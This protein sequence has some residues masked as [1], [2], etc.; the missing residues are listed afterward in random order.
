MN[1]LC[2]FKRMLLVSV[3]ITSLIS[4]NGCSQTQNTHDNKPQFRIIHNNDGTDALA[5]MWIDRDKPLTKADL[6]AYVDMVADAGSVTTYMMC[7]GS[8][9]VYYR[10][11]YERTFGDDLGGKIDCNGAGAQITGEALK[12][13]YQ[14]IQNL[15]KEG[16]DLIAGSLNRAKERGLEAFITFR[17]NDLHFADTLANCRLQYPDFWYNHPEYWTGDPTQGMNSAN[18][19]D[20]SHPEVREHKLN[21]IYEQLDKYDM[22]DGYDLDF[23]RFI[24]LFKTGEGE[25]NAP[26]ITDFVKSIKH[27]I[28]SL[29]EVRG[30]NILLSV[31]VPQTIEGAMSKGL[32]VKE[33]AKLGLIDFV[34]IGVHWRGETACPIAQ[35]KDDFGYSNIPVYGS[36]DDGGYRP[37]EFYSDG[38]YRGMASTILEQGGDGIY[39]FNF[40]FG[41]YNDHNR[42]LVTN[43]SGQVCRI[44]N[45]KLLSELGSEESLK[46]RNKIYCASDGTTDAYRVLQV[47][48]LPV[49]AGLAKKGTANIFIGDDVKSTTPEEAILYFRTDRDC[50]F[51]VEFNGVE[52]TDIRPDYPSIYDRDRGLE[53]DDKVFAYVVPNDLL[54]KGFNEVSFLSFGPSFFV[55]KRLEVGLKYG[56]VSTHGYF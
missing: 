55:V 28:D 46:N 14:N 3:S 11:A 9:F 29:S 15:E 38:M 40:Y 32:D 54:N 50:K 30:K 2:A 23:M 43:E 45:P 35:F 10:S 7:S 41:D 36:I 16:T 1:T 56:D 33:W 49:A 27:R 51:K 17:V 6:E 4:F 13:Y 34:S 8:D 39:L 37:R 31:R 5:N 22:I 26:L 19:L 24:V 42:Q 52:L 47:S 21:L 18:A 53:G 25:K 48:D 20:F 44:R 12:K